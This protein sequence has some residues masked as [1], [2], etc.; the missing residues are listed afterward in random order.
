MDDLIRSAQKWPGTYY[1][2]KRQERCRLINIFGVKSELAY[3]ACWMAGRLR[4]IL[5]GGLNVQ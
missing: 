5:Q 2:W 1:S 3:P 4:L